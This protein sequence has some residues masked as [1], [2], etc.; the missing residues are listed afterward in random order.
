MGGLGDLI[1]CAYVGRP[2]LMCGAEQVAVGVGDQTGQRLG[3]VGAVEADQGGGAAGVAVGGLGDLIHRA[4]AIS[5]A[6][7]CGAEQ[8]AV[9]I[10]DQAG[11]R[12]GTLGAD[13]VEA[14]QGGGA[15]GVAVGGLGNLEHRAAAV[16][17]AYVC[18]AEQV[19]VGIGDQAAVR[20]CTVGAVEVEQGSG[21]A[22][23]AVGGL[24]D[25]EH[26]AVA[27][28][29]GVVVRPAEYCCAEQV[30]VGISDQGADRKGT[31][32]TIEA[33]QGGGA[34]GVAVGG[35][36]DLEHVP[37]PFAPPPTV[38]PNIAVGIGDQAGIREGTVGAVEVDQGRKLRLSDFVAPLDGRLIGPLQQD[39]QA[40][41]DE[42]RRGPCG[43]PMRPRSY[44]W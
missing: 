9:G 24:G 26:R 23:V 38:V 44:I 39:L 6:L 37:R 16:R 2:A 5:P 29:V 34:A 4:I 28:R 30:A 32:G 19:A 11:K 7:R 22:G 27:R 25:L 14:D 13:A 21:G 10:G 40:A 35:L 18:R 20:Y 8:V 1:H 41:R 33:D 12:E 36:G 43:S 15:A 3:P 42:L 17:P 31:V